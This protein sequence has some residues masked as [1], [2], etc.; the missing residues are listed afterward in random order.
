[1]PREWKSMSMS[2]QYMVYVY[3]CVLSCFSCARLSATLWTVAH[4]APLC[5]GFSRQEYWSGLP[6]PP[7]GDSS[8]SRDQICV[9]CVSCLTSGFFTTSTTGK[10]SMCIYVCIYLCGIWMCVH[11]CIWVPMCLYVY[12]WMYGYMCVC[13]CRKRNEQERTLRS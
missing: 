6:C 10:S 1:M 11:I 3:V 9:S 7:P 8:Q 4:R 5:M 12:A 13:V 2:V